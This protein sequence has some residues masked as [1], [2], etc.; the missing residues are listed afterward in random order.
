VVLVVGFLESQNAKGGIMLVG[1]NPNQE[2]TGLSILILVAASRCRPSQYWELIFWVKNRLMSRSPDLRRAYARSLGF[3][4]PQ[5]NTFESEFI[6]QAIMKQLRVRTAPARICTIKEA[7]NLPANY[8]VKGITAAGTLK[9]A[10]DFLEKHSSEFALV[11]E[12]VPNAAS[13]DFVRRKL[14]PGRSVPPR[15]SL[16]HDLSTGIVGDKTALDVEFAKL[17]GKSCE[18]AD[19]LYGAFNPTEVELQAIERVIALDSEQYLRICTARVFLG[20]SAPHYANVLVT[21]DA[22]LV[23]IDH[24]AAAFESGDDLRMLFKFTKRDSL[25]FRILGDIAALT[26][27]DIRVAVSE[28]PKHRTCGSTGALIHYYERRL[29]LWKNLYSQGEVSK[30]IRECAVA[31]A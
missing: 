19:T 29:E 7:R 15:F 9:W 2:D 6:A 30:G 28:I 3:S 16:M 4:P 8:I 22:Q 20:C 12:V 21:Q 26:A 24:V 18:S 25:A 13:I 11:S 31:T 10:S 14:L 27:A 23:S 17:I 5:K 1:F